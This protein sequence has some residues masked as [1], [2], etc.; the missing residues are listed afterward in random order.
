MKKGISTSFEVRCEHCGFFELWGIER[1]VR[2]LVAVGKLSPGSEFDAALFAELFLH[3]GGDV[4][5]PR[6]RETGALAVKRAAP[7][8][9]EWDDAVRCE[10][11]GGEI[12]E[13][14]LKAVPGTPRCIRCQEALENDL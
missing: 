13:A 5:C 7:D 6:C 9:W 4:F 8:D 14:R 10:E 12:P 3:H 11:C 2:A 1:V